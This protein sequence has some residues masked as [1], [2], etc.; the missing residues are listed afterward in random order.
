MPLLKLANLALCSVCFGD[1]MCVAVYFAGCVRRL[2]PV[3]M[4]T[5]ASV[6][7]AVDGV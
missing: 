7:L 4:K 5:T 6:A 3:R 1:I 2:D